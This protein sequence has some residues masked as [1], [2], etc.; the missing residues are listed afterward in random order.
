M[1]GVDMRTI[2]RIGSLLVLLAMGVTGCTLAQKGETV[3]KHDKGQPP[4][5]GEATLDGQYALYKV[6][7]GTPHVTYTLKQGD[8]LGFDKTENGQL[9]AVAGSNRVPVANDG[10]YWRRR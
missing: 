4:I 1:K 5:L 6:L 8:K 9:I 7:D 3:V 10:Y 2:S